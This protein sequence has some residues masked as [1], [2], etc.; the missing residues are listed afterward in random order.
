MGAAGHIYELPDHI[1]LIY[2]Y[3][4][5]GA[6][7]PNYI[8]V[9]FMPVFA[10]VVYL[11]IVVRNHAF[12]VR[13]HYFIP[14]IIVAYG[15]AYSRVFQVLGLSWTIPIFILRALFALLA[16]SIA[17]RLRSGKNDYTK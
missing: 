1:R 7:L 4:L 5:D 10:L 14:F 9:E 2:E 11:V 16:V 12:R 17:F 15:L 6:F 8:T 3:W 13:E